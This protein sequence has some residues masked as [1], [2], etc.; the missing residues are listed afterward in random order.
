MFGFGRMDRCEIRER[1]GSHCIIVLV[2][3][4]HACLFRAGWYYD[5]IHVGRR[6]R[7]GGAHSF[8]DCLTGDGRERWQRDANVDIVECNEL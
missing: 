6:E 7:R 4:L 5:A 3:D 2:V 8:A 1:L